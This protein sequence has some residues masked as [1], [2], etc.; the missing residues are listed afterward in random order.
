MSHREH[1]HPEDDDTLRGQRRITPCV[2]PARL[3]RLVLR[4]IDLDDQAAAVGEIG[5]EVVASHATAGLAARVR[6]SRTPHQDSDLL[7]AQGVRA[8]GGGVECIARDA[9]MSHASGGVE[10]VGDR[11]DGR[12][13]LLDDG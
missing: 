7:L 3:G 9:A 6:E 8:A 10:L 2:C 12:Q 1:R 4:A 11:L 5:L 13:T